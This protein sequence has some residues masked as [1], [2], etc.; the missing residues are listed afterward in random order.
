VGN[1]DETLDESPQHRQR[2]PRHP[3]GRFDGE[4][5]RLER[6]LAKRRFQR[7]ARREV[8]VQR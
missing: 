8:P 4:S 5:G 3:Y 2:R 7:G 1:L 6:I